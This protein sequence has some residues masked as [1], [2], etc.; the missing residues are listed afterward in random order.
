MSYTALGKLYYKNPQGYKEEYQKRYHSPDAVRLDFPI[1]GNAAFFL[2]TQEQAN[3][4]IQILKADKRISL[5]RRKLPGIAIKQFEKRCLVDEIL[6]TNKIEGVHSTRKE[7]LTTL[8]EVEDVVKKTSKRMRFDGLI[9]KYVKLTSGEAVPLETCRDIRDLYDA[10]VLQEVME[11]DP[12]N[13]PDGDLFRKESSSVRTATDKEIHRGTYPESAIYEELESALAILKRQDIEMLYRIAIFHYLLEYIHPFY[14]GNGRLGRF[15]VSYLL[16]QELEP[17]LA[18]RISYTIIENINE[19]YTAFKVCNDPRN[20]GDLTPFV[21]MMLEM[22][23]KSV[24]QLEAALEKRDIRLR[25]YTGITEKLP[26]CDGRTGQVYYILIQASLFSNYG[27]S[28]K[29]LG[30]NLNASYATVKKELKCVEAHGLLKREKQGK[31]FYYSMDLEK[32][33]QF[34]L[35]QTIPGR[36]E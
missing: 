34:F 8:H 4:I 27:I 15:I 20:L 28:A 31:E 19:Y 2:Q 32:L 10:I 25:Y 29:E 13:E 12:D 9:S 17:V 5:L 6:L 1:N 23:R 3:I 18:Y 30:E 14:D 7:I 21:L 24:E 16:A 36:T 11:E 33:D 26:D 35:E 22:I